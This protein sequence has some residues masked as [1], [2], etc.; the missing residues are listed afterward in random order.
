VKRLFPVLLLTM[1]VMASTGP[2]APGDVE[3]EELTFCAE[4]VDRT[5]A[6]ADTAFA[7]DVGQVCCF[8]KIVG[9]ED[10]TSVFH[11]WI[12]ND[13][14]MAKVELPVRSN[15]WRTWSTK[16]IAEEWTGGWR[17]EVQTADGVILKSSEFLINPSAE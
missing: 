4:V 16:R 5:P 17:V 14:E 10:T 13:E 15:A 7:N 1:A 6:G 12:Y 2:A 3:V 9:A 8:T 11:V